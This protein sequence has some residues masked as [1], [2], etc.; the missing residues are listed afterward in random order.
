MVVPKDM[1]YRTNELRELFHD[2]LCGPITPA[3][4]GRRRFFLL[5]VDYYSRF[6]WLHLLVSKSEAVAAIRHFKAKVE[7][8][9][10]KKLKVLRTDRGG[11]FNSA[12]FGLEA[13]SRQRTCQRRS[14]RGG[15]HGGVHPKPLADEKL[16]RDDSL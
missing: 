9:T 12:E 15:E 1:M 3:T 6:M 10:V 16:E 5:L 7:T 4:H 14:G 2:D 11:E 13:C 8:K